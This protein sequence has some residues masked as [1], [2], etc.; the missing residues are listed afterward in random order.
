MGWLPVSRS[1]AEGKRP[2][3]NWLIVVGSAVGVG[4]R[5][6]L[7]AGSYGNYDQTSFQ[8]VAGIVA[9]GGNVYAE[10]F[11]Y[12]Y[13]PVWA[14]ILSA[15]A[16]VAVRT[17]ISFHLAFRG[18]LTL[19]DLCNAVVIGLIAAR[20]PGHRGDDPGARAYL[21]YLLNPV[22]ILIVGFHGQFD[23]L[24]AFPLL[25]A[26]LLSL[27]I[28][29]RREAFAFAPLWL[30]AMLALVVKHLNLFMVWTFFLYVC[31]SVRRAGMAMACAITV[32][33]LSFWP[34]LPGGPRRNH[35][36]RASV[37]GDSSALRTHDVVSTSRRLP[38][39]SRGDDRDS[40]DPAPALAAGPCDDFFDAGSAD[41]DPGHRRGV[42]HTAGNLGKRPAGTG[43]LDLFARDLHV[44]AEWAEQPAGVERLPAVEHALVCVVPLGLADD[45]RIRRRSGASP[46]SPARRR[47][48]NLRG[49]PQGPPRR[50][51]FYPLRPHRAGP[52]GPAAG[53][54]AAGPRG[55]GER[56]DDDGPR[57]SPRCGPR[58]LWA[59]SCAM[60]R[61]ALA[62]AR[63]RSSALRAR[64]AAMRSARGISKRSAGLRV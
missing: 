38:G 15:L 13:G 59:L 53:C 22:A 8:T 45:P 46:G 11:R 36:Q 30:L 39:V 42:F 54:E 33:L 1:A 27:R 47:G 18:F 35:P 2:I 26:V 51:E 41:P 29:H 23:N 58:A 56:A 25:C 21:A 48:L 5:L 37:P 43:I 4:L 55:C 52:D 50:S 32:F 63:A 62:F 9:R 10:T 44:F 64:I 61:S 24:A 28:R 14:L 20:M 49:R 17:G 57:P 16:G 7:A 31:S 19:V 34:F 60:R 3:A 12:N 6:W 40:A